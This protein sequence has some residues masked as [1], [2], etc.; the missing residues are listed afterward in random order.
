VKSRCYH[1]HK[2]GNFAADCFGQNLAMFPLIHR[3]GFH[4]LC[5]ALVSVCN[6]SS[7]LRVQALTCFF[8]A[9]LA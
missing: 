4:L 1:I 6:V 2:E 9:F 8:S 5:S 3:D 7:L